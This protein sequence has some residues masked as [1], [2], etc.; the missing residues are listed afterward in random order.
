MTGCCLVSCMSSEYAQSTDVAI[1]FCCTL[2]Y[3]RFLRYLV[4]LYLAIPLLPRFTSS[5]LG[6]SHSHSHSVHA[7]VLLSRLILDCNTPYPPI[8][9]DSSFPAVTTTLRLI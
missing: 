7:N 5:L 6:P 4:L 1:R 8:I 3:R 9:C 2:C